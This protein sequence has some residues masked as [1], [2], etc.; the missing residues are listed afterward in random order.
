MLSIEGDE[1][2]VTVDDFQPGDTFSHVFSEPG[3][4]RYYCSIHGS[5]TVG[6]V[7]TITITG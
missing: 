1:W 5:D 4:Y 2:G 7:G 6:M 3:E